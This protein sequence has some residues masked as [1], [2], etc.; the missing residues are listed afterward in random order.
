MEVINPWASHQ[1][2]DY[3]RLRD[4]FGIEEFKFDLPDAPRLFRRGII[5]GH[6]DFQLIYDRIKRNKDFAVLT[7]LMPSGRM[8]F[9]HKMTIDQVV[10]YQN[11]GGDVHIAVADI[12]A[13]ASRGISL[14][15]ARKIALEEYVPSYIALGISPERAEVYF[16]SKR[17]EVKD[18]AWQLGKKININEFLK[19]YGFSNEANM[20][21]IFSPLIQVGDILHVQLD[22][23]GGRRPTVVPVG[24]DQDPHLRLTRDL[25]DRWRMFSVV[26]QGDKIGVFYRGNEEER[27]IPEIKAVLEDFGLKMEENIPYKALYLSGF[28]DEK[29]MLMRINERLIEYEK[30]ENPFGFF[31]PSAT[32]HRLITGLTGEKMSSSVPDSAIFLTDSPKEARRKVMRAITGGGATLEEHRKYGGKPEKCSVYEFF[33]YHLIDDDKYLKEIYDSCKKGERTCGTCKKEAAGIVEEWM[34]EFQEKRE[35][36]KDMVKDI[37]R[38]D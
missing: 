22:R 32:Y 27:V 15:K 4:E 31:A 7:G 10:Y 24:V 6:R 11:H 33:A 9:G 37:V 17:R 23:F 35:Q 28:E 29:E 1:F 36:A 38:E 26:K 20:S 2:K 34:K 21:H 3:A 13:Y 30:R 14:E 8:H 19:I 25:V 16:Q 5:F 18:L 12:E